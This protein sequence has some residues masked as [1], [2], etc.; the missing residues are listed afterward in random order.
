MYCPQCSQSFSNNLQFCSKCGFPITEIRK[1]LVSGGALKVAT[2]SEGDKLTARQKGL[3]QGIKLI[4]LSIILYPLH[5]VVEGLL[6]SVEGTNMDELPQFMVDALLTILL[7]AGVIRI[8]Y[9]FAFDRKSSNQSDEVSAFELNIPSSQYALS[10]SQGIPASDFFNRPS[11]TGKLVRAR[12]VIEH[13]T[14]SL[15][16]K[17]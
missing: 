5:M 11:D 10:A 8:L 14:D 2:E 13:T 9:T 12:S 6:P 1:I 17:L 7:L 15:R 3:R 16:D 4:L